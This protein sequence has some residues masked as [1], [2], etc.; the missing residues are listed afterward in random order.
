MIIVIGTA[1]ARPETFDEMRRLALEHVQRSRQEPGCVSHD[2]AVDAMEPLQLT[3][4]ERWSDPGSLATHF[5]VD[6]SR[7]FAKTLTTLGAEP[8]QMSM[9]QAE[10]I[11]HS[12][13]LARLATPAP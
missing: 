11:S 6:A 9:Y 5:R 10:E 7:Q 1:K 3:F 4:T 13:L 8:P 12:E 2:V